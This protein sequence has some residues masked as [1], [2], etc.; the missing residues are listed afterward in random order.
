VSESTPE[1]R[2]ACVIAGVSLDTLR[3]RRAAVA[4][5]DRL[6]TQAAIAHKA[7]EE[8]DEYDEVRPRRLIAREALK[9]MDAVKP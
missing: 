3:E 6:R 7:L 9:E 4:E 8:I 1:E 2:E 5:L